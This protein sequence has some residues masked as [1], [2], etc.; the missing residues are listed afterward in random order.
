MWKLLFEN[1][2]H[3]IMVIFRR[4]VNL[5]EMDTELVQQEKIW[6][7]STGRNISGV[8]QTKYYY[9]SVTKSKFSF[10]CHLKIDKKLNVEEG[11]RRK[12][13]TNFDFSQATK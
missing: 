13:D 5:D 10:S 3:Y 12:T 1:Y 9:G 7:L 4:I 8:N 11:P 6:I 2:Y